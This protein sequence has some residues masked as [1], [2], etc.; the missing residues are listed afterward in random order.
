MGPSTRGQESRLFRAEGLEQ[1]RGA[2]NAP[3]WLGT[4]APV[5][6]APEAWEPDWGLCKDPMEGMCVLSWR[7]WREAL[8][9][10]LLRRGRWSGDKD[11]TSKDPTSVGHRHVVSGGKGDEVSVL[12][13][14]RGVH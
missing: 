9:G 5:G 6:R 8:P 4:G 12:L 3:A 7:F 1:I 13:G 11:Q 10:V 14:S 2:R